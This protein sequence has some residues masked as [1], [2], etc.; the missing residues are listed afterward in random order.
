MDH[1]KKTNHLRLVANNE[2]PSS[3][4]DSVAASIRPL[5]EEVMPSEEFLT[6]TRLRLL[7]L[8]RKAGNDSRQAAA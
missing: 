6:R 2:A 7:E 4:L 8:D 3:E 5:P 1:E